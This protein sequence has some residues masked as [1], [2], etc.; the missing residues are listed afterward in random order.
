ML[1]FAQDPCEDP[2]TLTFNL[3]LRGLASRTVE[4]CVLFAGQCIHELLL[5]KPFEATMLRKPV[6]RSHYAMQSETPRNDIF[7][8]SR[9]KISFQQAQRRI[10][11]VPQSH[12][13]C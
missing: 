4:E 7:L 1:N 10:R 11:G 6:A 8:R 9:R 2:Q 5:L 13:L 3:K 12:C